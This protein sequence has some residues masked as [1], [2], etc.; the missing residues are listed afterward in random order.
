M[1]RVKRGMMVRK[2]HN[3]LLRQAK[4]FR[5]NRSRNYKV[6]HEAVMHSLAAAYRDRRTKKRDMRRLW[7]VR[8]NAAARQHGLSYSRLMNALKVAGI[9]LDRKQLADLAVRDAASFTALV[10]SVSAR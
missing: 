4:G 2:R 5:G 3:K 6:A 7:I 10:Q 9:G 1:A 8:I